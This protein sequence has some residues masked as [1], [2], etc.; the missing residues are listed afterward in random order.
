MQS[1]PRILIVEDNYIVAVELEVGLLDAGFEVTGIADSA[2]TAISFAAEQH[3]TLAIMDVRLRGKR[4]GVDAAVE[5]F[6]ASG[7]RCIFATANQETELQDRARA[8]APLGWLSKPYPVD[9]VV[10]MIHSAV[11]EL[12]R[13]PLL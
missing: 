11:E 6:K 2:A 4:D 1:P 7:V 5:M 9:A 8:A 12:R 10:A 3:P 13:E